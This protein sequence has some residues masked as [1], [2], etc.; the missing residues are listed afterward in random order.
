[1]YIRSL[2]HSHA[3]SPFVKL[4]MCLCHTLSTHNPQLC[5]ICPWFWGAVWVDWVWVWWCCVWV[6]MVSLVTCVKVR[7]YKRLEKKVVEGHRKVAEVCHKLWN[8]WFNGSR[9]LCVY[10]LWEWC[11]TAVHTHTHTHRT[12]THAWT[13]THARA[14]TQLSH[15]KEATQ[16]ELTRA[17]TAK[18]KLESLCRE[19]QKQNKAIQ[20]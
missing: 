18:A 20:V 2:R 1:M 9:T 17:T 12:H 14:H 16:G 10:G 7:E 6:F 15:A 19:L 3:T 8:H 11:K 5:L 13:H 4:T